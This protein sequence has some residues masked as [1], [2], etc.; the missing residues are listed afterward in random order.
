MVVGSRRTGQAN[1]LAS[2]H[3]SL[4]CRALPIM[5]LL[6][7]MLLAAAPASAAGFA[8]ARFGG[9]HGSVVTTNPTALYYNP[10]GLAFSEGIHLMA[11]GTLALRRVTWEHPAAAGDPA[12]PAGG[13]GA[14]TGRAE[15]FNVFGAPML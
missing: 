11:D 7:G 9:E 10:A 3:G 13:E 6:S 5:A 8:T 1:T 15:L 4:C 2:A 12:D 14:N